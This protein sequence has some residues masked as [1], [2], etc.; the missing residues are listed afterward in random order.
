MSLDIKY[1]PKIFDD[2]LGQETEIESLKKNL[3]DID[4]SH[5]YLFIGPTG[6]GKTTMARV[7]ATY[8]GIDEFSITEL[9]SADERG[10]DSARAI[11]DKTRYLTPGGKPKI[12]IMNEVH[13]WT[14]EAK[15]ALLPVLEEPPQ[16]VY[17]F[18][19]TTNMQKFFQ[20][21]EGKAL[22]TRMT[23]VKVDPVESELVYRFIFKIAKK[24]KI[25]IDKTV[26]KKISE[27]SEGVPRT[28]IKLLEKIRGI[29]SEN[30]L[31]IIEMDENEEVQ[32]IELCRVLLNGNWTDVTNVI[33]KM[34]ITDSNKVRYIVSQYMG[35]V[36]LKRQHP[37]AALILECFAD[38]LNFYGRNAIILAAYQSFFSE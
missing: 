9:N 29:D 7:A 24:E 16:H 1:R 28:A 38:N 15:R 10:I 34:N 14:T 25:E 36:L 4:G 22:K 17:F 30:Q 23:I 37:K 5:V 20:G 6:C 19:T 8:L 21:D 26:L 13:G 35:T 3:G 27:I 18:L 12:F 31:K 32:A 11:I 2:I 33:S